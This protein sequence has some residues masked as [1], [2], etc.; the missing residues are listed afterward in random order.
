MERGA[1]AEYA[2]T[3]GMAYPANDVTVYATDEEGNTID[4]LNYNKQHQAEENGV[5]TKVQFSFQVP[6]SVRNVTLNCTSKHPA[7]DVE[8]SLTI[9]VLCKSDDS[10][11]TAHSLYYL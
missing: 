9:P 4:I 2:C 5:T 10:C 8:T 7:G 1:V 3:T 11:L 6:S